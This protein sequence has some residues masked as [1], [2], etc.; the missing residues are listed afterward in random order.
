MAEKDRAGD[1]A[2]MPLPLQLNLDSNAWQ[3]SLPPTVWDALKGAEKDSLEYFA[4]RYGPAIC[5]YFRRHGLKREDAQDLTVD[6]IIDKVIQGNLLTNFKP[7]QYRFRWYLLQALRHYLT[8]FFRQDK[9]RRLLERDWT[10]AEQPES[11]P[12]VEE[13]AERQFICE[14]AH[15]Q[16]KQ[17]L[18]LVHYECQRDGLGDHFKIFCSRHFRTPAPRWEE[19]GQAFGRDAQQA[20]NDAWTVRE[21]LRKAMLDEF[22][23]QGMTDAQVLD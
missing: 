8:D 18:R 10:A 2:G 7:G 3:R 12:A 20:K 9:R 22:R 1:Q 5:G 19:V 14:S 23:M 17:V 21:R 13:D 11:E 4:R 6:F 15:D 16:I